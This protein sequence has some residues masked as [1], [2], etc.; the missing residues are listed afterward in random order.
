MYSMSVAE[1]VV[2]I[3]VCDVFQF[4]V[5]DGLRF[6]DFKLKDMRIIFKNKIN[7]CSH[8]VLKQNSIFR[9]V[10]SFLRR[11]LATYNIPIASENAFILHIFQETLL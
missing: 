1:T 4:G 5:T 10:L 11:Y 7:Q 2:T 9:S 8:A 6:N 3:I